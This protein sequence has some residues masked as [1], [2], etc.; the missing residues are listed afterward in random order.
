MG[1]AT[2]WV[3]PGSVEAAFSTSEHCANGPLQYLTNLIILGYA[4]KY[5]FYYFTWIPPFAKMFFTQTKYH[6][7]VNT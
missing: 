1:G 5:Y 7:L 6:L 4:Q 2:K 3:E